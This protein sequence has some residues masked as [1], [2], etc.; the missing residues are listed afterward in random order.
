MA[1]ETPPSEF[2]GKTQ[3]NTLYPPTTPRGNPGHTRDQ[4]DADEVLRLGYLTGQ[5]EDTTLPPDGGLSFQGLVEED[6]PAPEMYRD[7]WS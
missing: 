7:R 3:K 4:L 2:G 1:S 6:V 5:D